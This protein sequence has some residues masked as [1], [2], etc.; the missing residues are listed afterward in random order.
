MSLQIKL[1]ASSEKKTLKPQTLVSPIQAQAFLFASDCL[2][3]P[4]TTSTRNRGHIPVGSVISSLN[5]K[6]IYIYTHTRERI[7]FTVPISFILFVF[8]LGHK[9]CGMSIHYFVVFSILYL[10]IYFLV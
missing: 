4:S 6:A 1:T 10:F 8:L 9:F 3:P 2:P 7:P 5:L